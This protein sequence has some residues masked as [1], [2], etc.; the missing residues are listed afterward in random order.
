MPSKEEIEALKGWTT[1]KDFHAGLGKEIKKI[2]AEEKVISAIKEN[3][4]EDIKPPV[5]GF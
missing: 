4:P 5:Q 3:I 1:E 2:L